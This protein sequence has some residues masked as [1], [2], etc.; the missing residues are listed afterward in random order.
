MQL[1]SR[2]LIVISTVFILSGCTSLADKKND[3][4]ADTKLE[5]LNQAFSASGQNELNQQWWLSLNDPQLNQL[6]EV[7]LK[8]NAN[9]KS[10]LLK[11]ER[12]R[13]NVASTDANQAFKVN[14]NVGV[15]STASETSI[16]STTTDKYSA[17]ISA[18]YEWDVWGRLGA[19]LQAS[20][21]ELKGTQLDLDVLAISTSAEVA[22][23]W[24]R[25]I[26]QQ[27]Q[28]ALLKQQLKISE[29]YLT[30]VERKFKTGLSLASDVL[31]QRQ[32]VE[33]VKGE[34]FAAQRQAQLYKNQLALL[35]DVYQL[36]PQKPEKLTF[37]QPD[38]LPL[39]GLK[40]D[41]IKRRP[42]VLKAFNQVALNDART[43][44]AIADSYPKVS[45]SASYERNG[46]SL[47]K[48]FDNW[49][50]NLAANLVV[51]ILDGDKKAAEVKKAK[52]LYQQSLISYQQSVKTAIKEV[53]D[54]LI[55]ES[56]QREYL[57]SL[58][59][60]LQLSN[61]AT[62]QI[63]N[64]YIKGAMDFQRVLNA[65]LSDQ[66]LQRSLIRAKRELMEYRIALYRAL[67]GS[68]RQ[69]GESF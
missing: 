59:K 30:L 41:L 33:S 4:Q 51:P 29:D 50:S 38:S 20:K 25:L 49:L 28:L 53:E 61:Q 15:S 17:G 10:N 6:I 46:T 45:F 27:Q 35:L 65:V 34:F 1:F 63:R 19:Q 67:A 12:A 40:A 2:S 14:G 60:Q 22:N 68:W 62:A 3:L 69:E 43:A 26:E 36:M 64:S 31:Q 8:N 48:I 57:Q 11:I 42:D 7:A 9:L 44:Q 32:T 52:N 16:T 47:D 39:T 54:A 37:P 55:K 18:S 23:N 24:Y 13:F 56:T 58:Q 5:N 21:L 66:N